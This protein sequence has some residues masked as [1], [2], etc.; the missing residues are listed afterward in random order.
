MNQTNNN[1]TLDKNKHCIISGKTGTGKSFVAK[2]IFYSYA[3]HKK[4]AIF[5][6]IKHDP[7]HEQGDSKI[8]SNIPRA[9]SLKQCIK[10][11]NT[12]W[13]VVFKLPQ[14]SS[15]DEYITKEVNPLFQY[16][17]NRGNITVFVDEA[18][19]ICQ[20][21]KMASFHYR[22]MIAGESL[23]VNV[24]NITQRPNVIDNTCLS[25]SEYKILFR[26][27]LKADRDKL[28]GVVGEE[29]ADKL[30]SLPK[31]DFLFVQA[32]GEYIQTKMQT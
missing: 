24:I 27:Q 22:S 10:M 17:L 9:T 20:T 13:L 26:Q 25:E 1:L 16:C 11:L 23:G 6:D 28:E 31:Y 5:V 2:Q 8:P 32:D 3:K 14:C 30:M 29:I 18:A 4:N 12:N 21:H 19:I 15:I 7:R